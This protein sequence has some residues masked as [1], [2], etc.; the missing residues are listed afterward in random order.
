MDMATGNYSSAGYMVDEGGTATSRNFFLKLTAADKI[1]FACTGHAH[2]VN[3]GSRWV[4]HTSEHYLAGTMMQAHYRA[5]EGSNKDLY[6]DLVVGELWSPLQTS[7][8]SRCTRRTDDATAQPWAGWGLLL[9]P[10][11]VAKIAS[12]IGIDRGAING[13]QM[14]DSTVL[15]A[16]L[17]RTPDDRGMVLAAPYQDFR[18]HHGY[19]AYNVKSALGCTRDTF[20]PFMSGSGGIS[21]L[22]MQNGTVYYQFSDNNTYDWLD[23]AVQS[24]K[25]RT[26]CN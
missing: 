25:I 13:V 6:T 2:Q 1:E 23:A 18:Y 24:N 14:L 22:L 3:P 9:M 5:L 10:D 4:Y 26:L 21:V 12:F 17:Q 15:D 11:D 7:P 16:A 8:T 20:L 19:W